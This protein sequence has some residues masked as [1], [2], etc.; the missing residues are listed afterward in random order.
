MW[1][2]QFGGRLN[3]KW[4]RIYAS[5]P[6]WKKG[7]FQNLIKTETALDLRKMPGI[8][9]KQFKGHPHAFP[10]SELPITAFDKAKFLSSGS[11]KFIWYGHSVILLRMNNKTILIDPMLGDDSSPIAPTKAKRFSSNTLSFVNDFPPIDL[12]LIT[13]DHYDHLDLKSILA[14]KNKTKNYFVSLGVK[15]HL[16]KW[17]VSPDSIIEFD[18]WDSKKLD[19]LEVTLSP[20]RHFSGRGLSSMAKCLWGGW[21]IKS[22]TESIWFSGD[23]GYGEHFTEIGEKL[24]PFDLAFMECGQYNNDWPD[25]HLFPHE[26]VKAAKEANVRLAVPVHWGGFSLSYQHS[27]FDP[28]EDFIKHAEEKSLSYLS[29][30]IGSI[31][32][33]SSEF[34]KWWE[35]YK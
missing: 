34:P 27:W 32:E 8:L 10:S 2:K 11:T 3:K 29:P 16:E 14:L 31:F 26:S 7:K 1:F 15:R 6:N 17:G 5:S 12:V 23:G 33:S 24:G 25:I 9:R 35:E 4:R 18:W 21:V 13:H 30:P 20:T 22:K 28:I 19:D